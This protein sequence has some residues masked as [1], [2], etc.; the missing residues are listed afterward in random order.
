[1]DAASTELLLTEVRQLV[2]GNILWLACR[3]E[4]VFLIKR[5][6][7]FEDLFSKDGK[8]KQITYLGEVFAL[9]TELNVSVQGHNL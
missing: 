1:M 7:E 9:C 6:M 2:K 4:G 8:L 3:I 5:K